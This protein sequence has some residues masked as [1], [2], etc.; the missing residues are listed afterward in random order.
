MPCNN[1]MPAFIIT[2]EKVILRKSPNHFQNTLLIGDSTSL[3]GIK[4]LI[5]PGRKS[6]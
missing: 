4:M 3:P 5:Q 2:G 6:E 1:A